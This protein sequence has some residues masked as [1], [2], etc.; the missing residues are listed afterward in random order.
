MLR[1][2]K[3][4]KRR[5]KTSGYEGRPITGVD[6]Q[7]VKYGISRPCSMLI[8]SVQGKTTREESRIP[9]KYY[10]VS[11]G[12]MGKHVLS[13]EFRIGTVL[14]FSTIQSQ[15]HDDVRYF[16]ALQNQFNL[17]FLLLNHTQN[18]YTFFSFS[19]T[20]SQFMFAVS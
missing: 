18:P 3:A 14:S 8:L 19:T 5:I 4:L 17:H 6:L 12:T 16:L 10:F 11:N 7:P 13:E 15:Y 9:Q 20:Q 1:W 2:V